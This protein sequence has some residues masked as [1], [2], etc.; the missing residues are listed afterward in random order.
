MGRNKSPKD[1]WNMCWF[2]VS[3]ITKYC[4]TNAEEAFVKV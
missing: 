2:A 4:L 1:L 3:I